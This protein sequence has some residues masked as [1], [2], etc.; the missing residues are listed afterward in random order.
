MILLIVGG[1]EKS[2]S[3]YFSLSYWDRLPSYSPCC[4]YRKSSIF[5]TRCNT[6]QVISDF[7]HDFIN[8]NAL[9]IS[10]QIHKK[11]NLER[12]SPG[13]HTR[14]SISGIVH[15]CKT[16]EKSVIKCRNFHTLGGSTSL[17]MA[18]GNRQMN[19]SECL[20]LF[21]SSIDKAFKKGCSC[22]CGHQRHSD[23]IQV[24]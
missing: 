24:S 17:V 15:V 9:K 4:S 7:V 8:F 13:T 11:N 12:S 3:S 18:L 10:S 19:R 22:G 20:E 5:Y 14:E 2:E 23:A 1:T 21:S 6:F 16:R